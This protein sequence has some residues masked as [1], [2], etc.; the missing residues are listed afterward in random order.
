MKTPSDKKTVALFASDPVLRAVLAE[1]LPAYLS[2]EPEFHDNAGENIFEATQNQVPQRLGALLED[3]RRF[4]SGKGGNKPRWKAGDIF[5]IGPWRFLADQS[6]LENNE[7]NKVR[8]TEKERDIL[9]L[10][11]DAKGAV[12][13][14]P[15]L[16][17]AIWDYNENIETHT[18]ETHIYRLRRKIEQ[19]PAAPA[20]LLTAEPGYR[21]DLTASTRL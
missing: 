1:A 5:A 2:I 8:L 4:T 12:I 14:R 19:D 17:T 20:L 15:D 16:L 7:G 9:F 6:L 3:I 13:P 21:L 11:Y 18:L 10:L